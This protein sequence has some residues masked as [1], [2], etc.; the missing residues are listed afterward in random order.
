PST[1]PYDLS[2]IGGYRATTPKPAHALNLN[3]D[4]D[5]AAPK[6]GPDSP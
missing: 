5:A 2:S 3:S 6:L 4:W 1:A